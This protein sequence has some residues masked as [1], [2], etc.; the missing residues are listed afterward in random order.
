MTAAATDELEAC[1]YRVHPSVLPQCRTLGFSS[2][3][4]RGILIFGEFSE[5]FLGA[6]PRGATLFPSPSKYHPP[7][8][9]EKNLGEKKLENAAEDAYGNKTTVRKGLS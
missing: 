3:L 5:L 8:P 9:R 2:K 7:F 1:K 4:G 6:R